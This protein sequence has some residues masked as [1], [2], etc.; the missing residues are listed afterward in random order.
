[1]ENGD[2]ADVKSSRA[3]EDLPIQ[4]Q[5]GPG[6]ARGRGGLKELSFRGV[7]PRV[8]WQLGP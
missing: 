7:W 4:A 2:G 5:A 6:Y 1:M 8:D 3:K